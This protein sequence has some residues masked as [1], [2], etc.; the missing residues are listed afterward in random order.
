MEINQEET[1]FFNMSTEYGSLYICVLKSFKFSP[2]TRK[3]ETSNNHHQETPESWATLRWDS[4]PSADQTA[5]C[6]A[7]RP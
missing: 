3:T 1:F 5:V 4:A 6:P 2:F 7:G